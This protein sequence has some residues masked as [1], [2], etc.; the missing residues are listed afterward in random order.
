VTIPETL[1]AHYAI[2][3]PEL[4]VDRLLWERPSRISFLE[5]LAN[6]VSGIF[7]EETRLALTTVEKVL[8]V[9]TATV[10][11]DSMKLMIHIHTSLRDSA[12]DRAVEA[13]EEGNDD[14]CFR[15]G[16][17]WGTVPARKRLTAAQIKQIFDEHRKRDG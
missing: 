1:R 9:D 4:D 12:L 14:A 13:F 10:E 15:E 5:S 6:V 7:G 16:I 8:D 17:M 3:A 11:P 2:E